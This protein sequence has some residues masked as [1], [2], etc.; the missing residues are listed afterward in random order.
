MVRN[1]AFA[2][3]VYNVHQSISSVNCLPNADAVFFNFGFNSSMANNG[4]HA[5]YVYYDASKPMAVEQYWF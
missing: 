2:G 1:D 4:V 5:Y 3:D